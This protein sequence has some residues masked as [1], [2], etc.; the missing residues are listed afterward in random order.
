MI[1]EENKNSQELLI[2]ELGVFEL[3]GLARE[4]GITSPTTKKR[5]ELINLILEKI[6]DGAV[7]EHLEK[8]KGRPYKKLASIDELVNL[9]TDV[10]RSEEGHTLEALTFAQTLDEINLVPDGEPKRLQGVLRKRDDS[11]QFYDRGS[12]VF[13]LE[14]MPSYNMLSEGDRV[15]VEACPTDNSMVYVATK[16]YDIN[17]EDPSSYSKKDF[18]LGEEVIST[19]TIPFDATNVLLGRRN[20]YLAKEEL[21]ENDNLSNLASYCSAHNIKL[22]VFGLNISFED[23][24]SLKNMAIENLT[25]VYGESK[26]T[27]LNCVIDLINRATNLTKKGQNILIY[28]ID[29]INVLRVVNSYFSK[30]MDEYAE[31]SIMLLQR[32][33]SLGRAYSSNVTSTLLICYREHDL[34]RSVF[35][36][37]VLRIGKKIN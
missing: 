22:L 30:N 8:K 14:D 2:R 6:Q 33:M 16:I 21:Y 13:I 37:E 36:D 5:E 10:E 7:I 17:G 32:V 26:E 29:I 9:L 35:V 27:N 15:T 34:E 18:D 20:L 19:Q 3:R 23:Q 11:F 25:T 31:E 12:S 28:V 1:K 24:I 4:I